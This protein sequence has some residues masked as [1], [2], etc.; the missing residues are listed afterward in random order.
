MIRFVSSADLK[1]L[2]ALFLPLCRATYLQ[3]MGRRSDKR[4]IAKSALSAALCSIGVSNAFVLTTT[5]LQQQRALVQ[6]ASPLRMIATPPEKLVGAHLEAAGSGRRQP[7]KDPFNP[8]F[9]AAAD[10]GVAYPS[11]TKEYTEIVHEPTGTLLRVPFRRIHLTDPDPGCSHI[12]VYDTSGPL[13]YNPKDGLPKLRAAWVRRREERGDK[14]FSQVRSAAQQRCRVLSVYVCTRS[15]ET[16]RCL[17]S[18]YR[19]PCVRVLRKD[20]AT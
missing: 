13:G 20:Y 19:N 14:R 6:S 17:Q 2:R 11:S 3:S 10:F 4:S 8:V 7:T 16:K 5:G 12:D 9:K 1:L 18:I 15:V